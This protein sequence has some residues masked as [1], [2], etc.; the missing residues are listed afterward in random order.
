MRSIFISSVAA[1]AAFAAPGLSQA[2]DTDFTHRLYGGISL[3]GSRFESNEND[4]S[5]FKLYGGYQITENFG[6]EMGYLRTGDIERAAGLAKSRA[7]YTAGTARWQLSEKFAVSGLMGLAYGEVL[8]DTAIGAD[9][10][11][12]EN[13]S[14]M[15]GIG[16]QYRLSP[17][18]ELT[19]NVDHLDK[20]TERVSTD[21]VTA[22]LVMRF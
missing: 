4:G 16:A 22:G 12:D 8:D 2:A 19:F 3:G 13:V 5:V 17:R 11:N 6:A 15:V 9:N 18:T 21:I 1:F 10:L 20:Q 14:V 7:F